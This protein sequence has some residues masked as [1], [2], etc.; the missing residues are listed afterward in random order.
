MGTHNRSENGRGTWVAVCSHCTHNDTDHEYNR[1]ELA[2]SLFY[3]AFSVI[4]LY[5][6][7]DRMIS[8]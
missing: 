4:G 7:D 6:V 1:Q 5:S 8:E 2:G 3:E